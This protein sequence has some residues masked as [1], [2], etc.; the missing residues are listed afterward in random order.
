MNRIEAIKNKTRSRNRRKDILFKWIVGII[1][2]LFALLP[3]WAFLFIK[4]ALTPEGF[5]QNFAVYGVGVW[6]LG[7]LQLVFLFI[8]I[9]ILLYVILES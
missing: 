5:W 8:W 7:G 6:F 1:T 3:T 9:G 2:L 4:S